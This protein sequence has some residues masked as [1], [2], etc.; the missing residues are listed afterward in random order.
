MNVTCPSRLQS[1]GVWH[2]IVW[3]VCTIIL[4]EPLLNLEGRKDFFFFLPEDVHSRFFQNVGTYWPNLIVS[5]SR[6]VVL[7]LTTVNNSNRKMCVR[8]FSE[9][10][11]Y[12]WQP[13]LPVTNGW[14][15]E[16]ADVIVMGLCW[17]THT[18]DRTLVWKYCF[19]YSTC[20]S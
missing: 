15:R 2:H 17:S 4:E 8:V 6:R 11:N 20:L 7:I 9:N 16:N 19:T 13:W 1:S 12:F 18:Q 14:L 10:R 3:Q 5:Y